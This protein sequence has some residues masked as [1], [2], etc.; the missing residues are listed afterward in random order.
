LI[1]EYD[2]KYSE[3]RLEK[4]PIQLLKLL[5][6][7]LHLNSKSLAFALS[8]SE[9]YISELL[10]EKKELS[11]KVIVSLSSHFKTDPSVFLSQTMEYA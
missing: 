11:K 4:Q 5:M 3:I 8:L 10:T 7:V 2:E 6:K 1:E 9:S